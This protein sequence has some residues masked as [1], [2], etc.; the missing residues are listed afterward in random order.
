MRMRFFQWVFLLTSIFALLAVA[1]NAT[2]FDDIMQQLDD[3]QDVS[4]DLNEWTENDT[5]DRSS[6]YFIEDTP[7]DTEPT[8]AED[9]G[10]SVDHEPAAGEEPASELPAEGDELTDETGKPTLL[11]VLSGMIFFM[12]LLTGLIFI[13]TL[14]ERVRAV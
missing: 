10:S 2:D 5:Q 12:G 3:G 11:A 14:F 8:P 1:V 13:K 7:Q 9:T 4:V 6:P